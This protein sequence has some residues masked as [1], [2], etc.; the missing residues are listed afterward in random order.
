M[1]RINAILRGEEPERFQVGRGSMYNLRGCRSERLDTLQQM[2][3][4]SWRPPPAA[5][6]PERRDLGAAGL[7]PGSGSVHH[8]PDPRRDLLPATDLSVARNALPAGPARG[9]LVLQRPSYPHT[10]QAERGW[11]ANPSSC[12]QVTG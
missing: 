7:P 9:R 10:A 3:R 11:S 5:E 1:A 2:L 4:G 6:P 12:D 8:R